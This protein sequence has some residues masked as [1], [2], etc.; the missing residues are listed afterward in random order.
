[1]QNLK[2]FLIAGGVKGSYKKEN[3]RKTNKQ[4]HVMLTILCLDLFPPLHSRGFSQG[5][6]ISGFL[7]SFDS[8]STLLKIPYD[9][10]GRKEIVLEVSTTYLLS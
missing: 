8:V 7:F 6:F 10:D 4:N 1:M 3:G 9:F 2:H 5:R